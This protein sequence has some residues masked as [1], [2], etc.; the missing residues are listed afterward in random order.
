VPKL[1]TIN[2]NKEVKFVQIGFLRQPTLQGKLQNPR[3]RSGQTHQR[4][5]NSIA[6]K[7]ENG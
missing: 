4:M 3:K 6:K 2:N 1:D 7:K 5:V